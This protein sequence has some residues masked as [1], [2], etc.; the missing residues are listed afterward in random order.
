[1]S[2]VS[3]EVRRAGVADAAVVARL[4][5]EFNREFDTP[6]PG[7]DVLTGRLER[8]LPGGDT[9][10]LLA[11]EPAV[12]L[13][14]L[15]FR[16]NVWYDGPVAILDELY[17]APALRSRGLGSALLRTAE[18]EVL[19]RDGELLEINVDAYDTDAR[20][21]YERHGYRNAEV[22]SDEPL[23]YYFRELAG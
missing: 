8:L 10:A 3:D 20:R 7:V 22:G 15:T 12:G 13:A 23:L 4:L 16:P 1:M 6:T 2:G 14:L 19:R 17:V 5:D 9:V 21:F 11:R 18:Q